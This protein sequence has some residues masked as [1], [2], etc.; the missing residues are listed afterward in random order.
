MCSMRVA[1]RW[2]QIQHVSCRKVSTLVFA[3]LVLCYVSF[4]QDGL[5]KFLAYCRPSRSRSE[6]ERRICQRAAKYKV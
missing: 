1:I 3:T 2:R 6:R 5:E 4:S